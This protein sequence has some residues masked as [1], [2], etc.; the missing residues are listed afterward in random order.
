MGKVDRI[1]PS[2]MYRLHQAR[3]STAGQQGFRV[4]GSELGVK[5][6]GNW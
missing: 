2:F 6:V 5:G 1:M 4:S 3:V